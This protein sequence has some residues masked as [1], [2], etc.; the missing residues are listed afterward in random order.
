MKILGGNQAIFYASC[1]GNLDVQ[2][3]DCLEQLEE[4]MD[5]NQ[6]Y[7]GSFIRHNIFVRVSD[8]T[9][10]F[11]IKPSLLQIAKR[12]FPLPLLVNFIPAAPVEGDVALESTH[13]HSNLWNCLFKE[14][15]HGACQHMKSG[16]EEVVIG[17]IT[18]NTP[19]S[20]SS[21]VE[22]AFQSMDILLAKCGME[23]SNI[24]RQWTYIERMHDEDQGIQRYQIFND[25]R[26]KYYAD[27]FDTGGYPASTE[28]GIPNGGIM[29]EFFAIKNRKNR[30]KVISNPLQ[31]AP[32][33]YSASVL[34]SKG[35]GNQLE[36]TTP[37]VE[38]AQY[39]SLQKQAMIFVTATPAIVGER[40][41]YESDAKEQAAFIVENF[42]KL[43]AATNLEKAGIEAS[44]NGQISLIKGY[45]QHEADLQ[46][47]LKV[48]YPHFSKIPFVLVQASLPRDRFLVELEAEMML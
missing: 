8:W 34:S 30:T 7:P 41:A 24:V 26:S 45:V 39:F 19:G 35:L 43:L 13:I 22:E 3:A 6:L 46:K 10:F 38:R 20:F 31:K 48:L 9:Q 36:P 44:G 47:V 11:K 37:K 32:H 2:L 42:K 23:F 14:H 12:R 21:Q 29:I 1:K 33:E 17:S 28:I 4:Y 40:I 18:I 16:K 27:E 25:T 15:E 5:E